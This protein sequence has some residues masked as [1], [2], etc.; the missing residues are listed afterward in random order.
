MTIR[1]GTVPARAAPDRIYVCR[2]PRCWRNLSALAASNSAEPKPWP[3][4]G[5][6]PDAT[7]AGD[8]D[9]GRRAA[10]ASS[11]NR[12]STASAGSPARINA[13][14]GSEPRCNI[15]QSTHDL[16]V[17]NKTVTDRRSCA[18]SPFCNRGQIIVDGE[19]DL[20]RDM[21]PGHGFAAG[22]ALPKLD[23]LRSLDLAQLLP[24]IGEAAVALVRR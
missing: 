17:A 10:V 13:E 22:L 9:V 7:A 11:F 6:A 4:P 19:I 20:G 18:F 3:E 12:R 8:G 2:T 1:A 16:R 5:A 15:R 23:F 21:R 14:I 24:Q